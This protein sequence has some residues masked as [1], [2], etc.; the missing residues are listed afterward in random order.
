M[1]LL[2]VLCPVRRPITLDCV[3]LKDKNIAV[4]PR[5]GPEISS[6]ACLGVA[7]TAHTILVI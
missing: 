6:Q 1:G 3:L 5:Q 4:V 7:E 2:R